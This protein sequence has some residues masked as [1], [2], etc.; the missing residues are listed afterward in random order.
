MSEMGKGKNHFISPWT[1]GCGFD[2]V[3]IQLV[4]GIEEQAKYL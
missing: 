4:I 2:V 1:R 3:E